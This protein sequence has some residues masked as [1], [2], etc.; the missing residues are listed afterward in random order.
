MAQW[1]FAFRGPELFV[2]EDGRT[3]PGGD[4]WTEMGLAP[5]AV[6]ALEHIDGRPCLA[7]DLAPDAPTP[8]GM[9]FRGL[10]SLHGQLPAPLFRMAGRAF[11]ILDWD[12]THRFCGRCGTPTV[13]AETERVRRC[14]SCGQLHFPRIAPAVITLIQRGE[15]ILMVRGHNFPAHFYGL[16]AGFVEPGESLEEAVAREIVEEVGLTVT[17]VRYWGSQPWPF[18]HSL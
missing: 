3:L 14:P 7:L 11:Q 18:P 6:H 13:L 15:Q 17:N 8:T 5:T 9:A 12:R 4:A 16:V 1:W 10:R 2:S